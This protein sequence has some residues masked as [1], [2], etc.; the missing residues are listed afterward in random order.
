MR[1]KILKDTRK[2]SALEAQRARLIRTL[3]RAEPLLAGSLSLVMRTCGKP[4]CHC[5]V[6]PGHAVWTLGT[7][8]EGRRRCQVVR[9]N[10]VEQV[11][12]RVAAYKSFKL[13]L[14]EIEAVENDV[15]EILRGL[16]ED[17]NVPYE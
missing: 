11:R 7:T 10:D 14:A 4:A 2:L 9:L 8:R 1:K 6:K 3:T 5:A 12:R 13:R 17:R 16:M 15:R